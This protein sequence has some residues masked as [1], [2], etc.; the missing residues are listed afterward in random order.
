M[1][2]AWHS[3]MLGLLATGLAGAAHA[4]NLGFTGEL[5]LQLNALNPGPIHVLDPV[6]ISGVGTALVNG[7]DGA[8]HLGG[9]EVAAGDFGVERFAVA[10]SETSVFPILGIQV[11]VANAAGA[12]HGSGGADFGGV[13]PLP[14]VAKVCLFGSGACSQAAANLSIPLSVVGSGGFATVGRFAPIS[15]TV[16]G[17]PWT[18]GTVA[19]GTLTM[20]GG[21]APLSNTGAPSGRIQL[22]TPIFITTSWP[23]IPSVWA[24]G[25]L[26]LHF[27]PEPGTL[28]LLAGGIVSLGAA[29]RRRTRG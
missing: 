7:S 26:D 24:F 10:I 3:L 11:T 8:G 19:V 20:K 22:V 13:M 29:G 25:I 16:V 21:V 18:T 27:V 23:A 4:V 6:V 5:S 2:R 17:A 1:G 12:F 9:I 28:V 15:V 14:G